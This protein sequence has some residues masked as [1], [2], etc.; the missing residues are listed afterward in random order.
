MH[1]AFHTRGHEFDHWV[2]ESSFPSFLLLYHP[3]PTLRSVSEDHLETMRFDILFDNIYLDRYL[4][5]R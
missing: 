5:L 2:F 3:K 1:V 4:R